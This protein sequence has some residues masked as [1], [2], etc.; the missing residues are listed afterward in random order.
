M[1]GGT[2]MMGFMAVEKGFG[3]ECEECGIAVSCNHCSSSR[4]TKMPRSR[5]CL[6]SHKCMSKGIKSVGNIR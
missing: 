4:W 3:C 5:N 2:D 1:G 6:Y